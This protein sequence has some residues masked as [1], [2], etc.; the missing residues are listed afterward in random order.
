MDCLDPNA[1]QDYLRSAATASVRARV[2]EHLDTCDDCRALVALAAELLGHA[3]THDRAEAGE[4]DLELDPTPRTGGRVSRYRLGEKLGAGAMGVV[5]AADDPELH[6]RIAIKLL[7]ARGADGVRET[8]L[9]RE[10]Q[11]L[12][13]VSD[14]HVISVFDVG[15][16][17]G[18]VFLAMEL[19]EG[20]DLRA[21]LGERQRPMGEIL[22]A[23]VSA[24][25]GLVAAHAA[26]L[27]HRDFKPQNVLVGADGRVRVTD[28]GLARGELDVT[29]LTAP[30]PDDLLAVE[31]TH[32]RALV[33]TPAYMAPEQLTGGAADAASDQFS[34]C[35]A[36]YEA[37]YDH[38][39]FQAR[40]LQELRHA[41]LAGQV[42]EEPHTR[43]P[44]VLRRI[45]LRGLAVAPADRFPSMSA[46]V[47]ALTSDHAR[48]ARRLAMA[49][50]GL[51]VVLG[52]VL[53]GDAVMRDRADDDARIELNAASEQLD[54]A[55]NLRYQA[56][57]ALTK[58]TSALP[59]I[60]EVAG[61]VDKA[62]FG[63]GE[64]DADAGRLKELHE[65]LASADWSMWTPAEGTIAVADYKGRLIYSSGAPQA[66]G[67]PL[68]LLEAVARAFDPDNPGIA[69]MI[70]AGDDP[71]L[72]ASGLFAA[73][74]PG[75]VVVLARSAVPGG[76]PRA[77]FVQA[78]SGERL[79][80][81]LSL[82][83]GLKLSLVTLDV[84]SE[85]T[86][87]PAVAA[88]ALTAPDA[89]SGVRASDTSWLVLAHPIGT[90]DDPAPVA[91]MVIARAV[92]AGIE[93]I[94]PRARFVVAALAAA[95]FAV[96]IG[97]AVRI[98]AL[99]LRRSG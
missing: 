7:H 85:G 11:A 71:L 1:V 15:T 43:V 64:A 38:R 95:L 76:V 42:R 3:V 10:A 25:R 99:P 61:N 75:L 91:T 27:V 57:A 29:R 67:T 17:D 41:V 6:R 39:P 79:L 31:L 32:G 56:F 2:D 14:P 77:V 90:P 21:W 36:L 55:L 13:R 84:V 50:L 28:F 54:R 51:L 37:L 12:A 8:R 68:G 87:P 96:A 9:L 74:R 59:V 46:L 83:A 88:A 82:G 63:L 19:V 44:Q 78:F 69:A 70:V 40:S 34:F 18:Q 62:E 48:G 5:Y 35:V 80:E 98:R 16:H 97:A 92:D 53:I 89:V 45:L 49:A 72:R 60:R 93:R 4:L 65:N 81:D 58:P 24:G 86:V 23:F 94:V 30:A 33:G 66:F 22:A 20:T 26:G 47:A 73:S 52:A